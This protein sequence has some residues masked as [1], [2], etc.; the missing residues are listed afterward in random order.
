MIA[1]ERDRDGIRAAALELL[2]ESLHSEGLERAE[3]AAAQSDD[4]ERVLAA[5]AAPRRLAAGYYVWVDYLAGLETEIAAGIGA[6]AGELPGVDLAGVME[7]R[8]ARRQFDAEHP[9]CRRCGKRLANAWQ[10]ACPGC[11]GKG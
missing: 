2:E 3:R 4:P 6:S 1:V 10:S 9:R 7:L 11:E 8:A 5:A